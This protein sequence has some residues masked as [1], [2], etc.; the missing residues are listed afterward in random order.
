MCDIW[1]TTEGR[2]ISSQELESQL[3]SIRRLKVRWVVLSGGEPLMHS[4]LWRLTAMLRPLDVRITV[5]SSGL[6]LKRYANELVNSVDDVIVSLDG[7][8]ETHDAIR[9]VPGAFAMLASGIEQIR[10]LNPHFEIS[11]RCTVQ[12]ANFCH[13]IETAD[14]ARR[15]NLDSISFLAADVDSSAFHRP[16]GWPLE[17]KTKVALA[18]DEITALDSAIEHLIARGDCGGFIR[19]SPE[20]LRRITRHFRSLLGATSPAAPVCNAPWKSAVIEADGAVRPCFFHRPI[21][22]I[23]PARSLEEVLNS[24]DAIAFRN[25]LDMPNNPVCQ[26]CVCS[27]NWKQN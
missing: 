9:G 12:R 6:L 23:G 7:P 15:L 2:E 18:T 1:K 8:P 20:K 19:E 25:S 17:R 22:R 14:V 27:L 24:P 3:A 5:L 26:K 4:D 21:G 11:A 13:L 10:H 16:D